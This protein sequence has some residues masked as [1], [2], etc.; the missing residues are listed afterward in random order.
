MSGHPPASASRF[1]AIFTVVVGLLFVGGG[2]WLRNGEARERVTLR[3]AQGTV[4]DS[5][6]RRD[7]DNRTGKDV[8]SYAPVIEFQ[9]NGTPTR[10]TGSY[11]SFRQ[12]NGNSVVVRYDPSSPAATARV[13]EALERLTSWGM[14]VLGG[15]ALLSGLGD[16]LKVRRL[17]RRAR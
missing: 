17:F 1:G 6:K 4:V 10:F 3:E 9:L 7:R 11:V 16:L 8:E 15:L 13:V 14:F 2:G 12:S 5:V